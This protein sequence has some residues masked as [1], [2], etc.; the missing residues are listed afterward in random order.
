MD[1]KI[2]TVKQVFYIDEIFLT[3][4]AEKETKGEY[5]KS[6][7]KFFQQVKDKPA[8]ELSQAQKKW[9]YNLSGILQEKMKRQ[10]QKPVYVKKVKKYAW[11][12]KKTSKGWIWFNYYYE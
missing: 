8:S 10:L 12:P 2:K 9:L 7:L 4:C 3:D 6:S 5:F 11:L 1:Q